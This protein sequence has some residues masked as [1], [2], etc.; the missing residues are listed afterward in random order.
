[1]G[2][3]S[4]R[5]SRKLRAGVAAYVHGLLSGVRGAAAEPRELQ[6]A[7]R[8]VHRRRCWPGTQLTGGAGEGGASAFLTGQRKRKVQAALVQA[9]VEK[10]V[11]RSAATSRV[12]DLNGGGQK[13][14]KSHAPQASSQAWRAPGRERGDGG[15]GDHA[16][17]LK[18]LPEA[19][20]W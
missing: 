11:R 2:D 19:D 9:A 7:G 4:P 10:E 5:S 13:G 12:P 8:Q 3:L 6:G 16:K 17:R 14:H 15:E 1:V 18:P 20:E